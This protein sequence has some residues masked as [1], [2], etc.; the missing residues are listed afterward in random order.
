MIY[1]YRFFYILLKSFLLVLKPVLSEKLKNWLQLRGEKIQKINKFKSTYWFHAASGEIEYCKSVIRLLKEQQPEC[2]IV[3][4]YSSPSAEKLFYNISTYVDQFI[5]LCWDQPGFINELI[6]YIHPRVLVFSRTD[7]WPEL[8]YQ[9]KKNKEQTLQSQGIHRPQPIKI[10]IISF[11]PKINKKFNL[12]N[13]LVNKWLLPQLDFISDINQDGDT[14]FDQVFYRLSQESKLKII[15]SNKVFVC[16]STWPADENILFS[17]FQELMSQNIKIVLSPHEVSPNN[18]LRI[19]R[20]LKQRKISF[21]LLS[22]QASTLEIYL[23]TNLLL[24]DKIGYLADA[25]RYASMAFVGGAY[26]QKVH[27][28]M[29][30]LCCGL[31]V[32]TGPH[33][34]NN[35]EAVKYQNQY[36]FA[37]NSPQ[38]IL[39]I[40]NKILTHS[41]PGCSQTD[42]LN[43]M[44][45]NKNVSQKVLALLVTQ[46]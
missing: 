37:T 46:L 24:I 41:L 2:Q 29:E 25:Y 10:G 9:I 19:Q 40:C 31:P 14:R 35:P 4:T 21:Q 6:D 28:V 8:I 43:T 18:I 12:L 5:P 30:P 13:D 27:S 38:E 11:N 34:R 42:I 33:Y 17:C 22:N 1:I 16:G 44:K 15:T 3:V 26:G 36:V 23:D 20:E 32:I 7:L 39:T 45:K